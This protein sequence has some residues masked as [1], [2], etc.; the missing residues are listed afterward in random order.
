MSATID[1]ATYNAKTPVIGPGQIINC[2]K[3]GERYAIQYIVV[4]DQSVCHVCRNKVDNQ[5]EVEYSEGIK[6]G[7]VKE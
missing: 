5:S 3:C 2:P 4:G 6:W 7:W 1:K